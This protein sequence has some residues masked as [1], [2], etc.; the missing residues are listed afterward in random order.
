MIWKETLG[1]QCD[2]APGESGEHTGPPAHTQVVMLQAW[3][4]TGRMEDAKRPVNWIREF[5]N[6]F[7]RT[8]VVAN[9]SDT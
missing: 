5:F 7:S 8:A 2:G 3:K 9:L 4:V 6:Y 1:A